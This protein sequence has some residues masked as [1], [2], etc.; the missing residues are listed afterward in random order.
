[1][2]K[3]MQTIIKIT[4]ELDYNVSAKYSNVK[5]ICIKQSMLNII[6]AKS[7]HFSSYLQCFGSQGLWKATQLRFQCTVESTDFCIQN[8]L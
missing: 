8:N 7:Q 6:T 4:L 2:A 1:M 5:A 3:R